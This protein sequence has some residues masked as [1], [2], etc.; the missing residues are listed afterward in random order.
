M[1]VQA[2]AR[3]GGLRRQ[4]RVRGVVQGVGFRPFVYSLASELGLT[5]EV[6]NDSDGV[7][8]QVQG[9]PVDVEAF[10]RRVATDAPP[11]A[12]VESVD[13]QQ[14]PTRPG[15]GFSIAASGGGGGRTLVPPDVATCEQCLAELADPAGENRWSAV[16]PDSLCWPYGLSAAP[17]PGYGQVL[18]IADSGNNRVVLWHRTSS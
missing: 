12:Q 14:L 10:C 17:D 3:L 5:G 15:A 1:T 18:A 2:G 4:V 9:E 8:V 7:L 6:S 11:L 16:T 13:W